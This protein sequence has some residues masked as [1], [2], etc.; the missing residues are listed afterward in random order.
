MTDYTQDLGLRSELMTISALL[1]IL[2]SSSGPTDV[3]RAV[4]H[5]GFAFDSTRGVEMYYLDSSSILRP[6]AKYGLPVNGDKEL[7]AWDDSPLSEA[8]REKRMV[9]LENTTD[10]GTN[11]TI[12]VPFMANGIPTGLIALRTEKTGD[13]PPFSP[14]SLEALQKLGAFYLQ[15]LDFGRLGTGTGP[16]AISPGDLSSRQLTI[17]EHIEDGLVN[18]EIAKILMLS[19]STIRQETVRIYRALGVSNRQEAV[20]KA[21]AL[22]LLSKRSLTPPPPPASRAS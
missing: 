1:D 5:A 4:A 11:A 20:K 22:G 9:I 17:L 12:A 8:I 14:A 16:I 19:E 15:T 21:R 10:Q 7:S 6:V 3:C 13:T 2:M 18:L